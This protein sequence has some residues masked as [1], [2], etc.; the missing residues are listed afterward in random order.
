MIRCF[1]GNAR[2]A[3]THKYIYTCIY[4]SS[5]GFRALCLLFDLLD[6][7]RTHTQIFDG[8]FFAV[9]C[10]FVCTTPTQCA[11]V[12]NVNAVV[13]F[14]CCCYFVAVLQC[15]LLQDNGIIVYC[16][17]CRLP[18]TSTAAF[19]CG[20]VSEIFLQI[21]EWC[22]HTKINCFILFLLLP[23]VAFYPVAGQS[24]ARQCVQYTSL[25]RL[26]L[27]LV[28]VCMYVRTYLC[29]CISIYVCM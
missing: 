2:V 18:S 13:A 1:A 27:N 4:V 14:C 12:K 17:C 8:A 11:R 3:H 10:L 7:T 6:C 15:V 29:R 20:K 21:L 25:Y 19:E 9:V 28:A 22:I 5:A 16:C 26:S 24:G 23:Y